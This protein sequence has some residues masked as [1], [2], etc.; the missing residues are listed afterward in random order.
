MRRALALA[1]RGRTTVSPNPLVGCVIAG[2]GGI[3][4]EGFHVRAGGPHAEVVALEAAGDRA[5]GATA[6]VTLE[7]CA[8]SGRTPPCTQALLAA[9]VT[10]VVAALRDPDPVACGG[11]EEL[12]SAGVRVDL[13]CCEEEAR[14]QNAVFLSGLATGRPFVVIKAAVSLD[15]R[16]AAA[17][18]TSQWL[19]G[20]PTRRR[21]HELRAE[22]DAVVVGSQTVLDDDPALTVRVPGYDG[23]PPLR[24]VLDRRGRVSH[25]LRVL[26][27][28][29]PTLLHRGDLDE[30]LAV[31][32]D[33]KVRSALVEG[34]AAVV[35]AFLRAG[36]ADRVVLHVAPVLLGSRGR[37]LV[38]GAWPSSLAA[39]PRL[40]LQHVEQ[41]GDDAVL[42]YTP[43]PETWTKP[44]PAA[45][46]SGNDPALAVD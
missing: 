43:R 19:T 4:G 15:G 37:P 31:L 14:L 30:L 7:P 3:V 40:R 21:A 36:L 25:G 9:G 16:I 34:G 20:E 33:R 39:A 32:W 24:V 28:A 6:Y 2:G 42:V 41:V 44:A 29:A 5:A 46:W 35:A 45:D 11:A 18:G 23:P 13:G 17:D 22:A 27:D 10:R 12:R 1:E 26:D 8:H 38:A